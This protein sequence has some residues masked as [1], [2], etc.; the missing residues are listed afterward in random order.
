MTCARMATVHAAPTATASNLMC[1]TSE[2]KGDR[3]MEGN[4]FGTLRRHLL[5]PDRSRHTA[6]RL[7][8]VLARTRRVL[9]ASLIA[10]TLLLP[11]APFVAAHVAKDAQCDV[12]S[13]GVSELH[14]SKAYAE[15]FGAR[16]SG[17]LTRVFISTY[18]L[19]NSPATYSVELWDADASGHPTGTSPLASTT[20]DHPGS[21]IQFGTAV[22]S[23]PAAVNAGHT[24]SLVIRVPDANINA[25]MVLPD[26]R[27]PGTF[28]L[29][30][31]GTPGTFESDLNNRDMAFTVFVKVKRHHHH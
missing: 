10:A 29:S 21:S 12:A 25:V 11:Y 15:S 28:A 22:F 8:A 31:N 2:L 18:N 27:C 16:H 9:L 24:Y 1:A 20:V 14:G 30:S 4:Q 17:A 23:T 26:D 7:A 5:D 3:G 13:G 19:Q 6:V